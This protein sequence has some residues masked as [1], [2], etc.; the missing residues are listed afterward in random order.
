MKK[1]FILSVIM[2]LGFSTLSYAQQEDYKKMDRYSVVTGSVYKNGK[3]IHGYIKKQW[4]IFEDRFIYGRPGDFQSN[5]KFIPKDV[6]DKNEKIKGKYFEKYT[7]KDCDGYKYDTL[8]FESVKY[9]DMSAVGTGMIAKKMFMNKITDDKISIYRHYCKP[10]SIG[11]ANAVAEAEKE[12]RI[13]N[14][15][16]RIGDGKLKLVE[17][18]N[19]KKE[20]VDCQYIIDKYGKKEKEEKENEPKE[21]G[22]NKFMNSGLARNILARVEHRL[23][24]I[25]D[26]NEN[27]K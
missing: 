5:F 6:F 21:K 26:Y 19:I 27:C 23:K 17:G 12:C 14:Y 18:L 20:L 3:E 2:L 13:P 25:K 16:Y 1:L 22:L 10:L 8:I 24:V 7:P 15:V 4:V 11:E 9:A